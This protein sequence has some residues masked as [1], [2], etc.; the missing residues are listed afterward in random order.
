MLVAVCSSYRKCS[1]VLQNV[2]DIADRT[3]MARRYWQWSDV[4][5]IFNRFRSNRDE[6]N[7]SLDLGKHIEKLYLHLMHMSPPRRQPLRYPMLPTLRHSGP[8]SLHYY[9]HVLQ[10]SMMLYPSIVITQD[11]FV[12]LFHQFIAQVFA[13]PVAS[14]RSTIKS[15]VVYGV[16]F[17]S[18]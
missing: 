14:P 3:W 18:G 2:W 11:T 9:H 8:N 4:Q 1:D 17:T 6:W 13:Q 12:H 7:G 10:Y 5:N 15:Y 16:S